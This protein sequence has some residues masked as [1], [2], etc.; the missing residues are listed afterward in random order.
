MEMSLGR[1]LRKAGQ[2]QRIREQGLHAVQTSQQEQL[3]RLV[4]HARQNSSFYEKLYHG[5]PSDGFLLADLPVTTKAVIMEHYDGVVT[6]ARLK[7]D[8]VQQFTQDPL[9][10][11]KAY[12]GEFVI[13]HTSGTT[14]LRGFVAQHITE[15]E[16]FFALNSLRPSKIPSTPGAWPRL[17]KSIFSGFRVAVI[18]GTGV[19]FITPQAFLIMP[20]ILKR[21][22]R[23]D[24]LSTLLPVNEMVDRLNQFQPDRIHGYPTMLEALAHKQ[25]EGTLAIRPLDISTSSEPLTPR[26]RSALKA[27][28]GV[29]VENTYGATETWVMAKECPYGQ[30]H[31]FIDGCIVEPVDRK[32]QPTPAGKQSA[33][34]LVT[35]LHNFSQP[36]LRYEMSDS[37]IQ[38]DGPCPCGSPL[39]RITVIGREDDTLYCQAPDG[40]YV[41]FPPMPLETLMLEVK[42]YSMFQIEQVERNRIRVCFVPNQGEDAVGIQRQ[43]LHQFTTHFQRHGLGNSV[44]VEVEA[45]REVSRSTVSGKGKQIA[46]LVGPPAEFR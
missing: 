16:T 12:Q 40:S 20:P 45:V 21:L 44:T 27:A 7:K 37:V 26:A 33:R 28:F 38:Q 14:G 15:W 3:K 18:A 42:G 19:Y 9:N 2:F 46:S 30:M 8:E 34:I 36:I 39:P 1:I 4:G 10:E 17:L 24:I 25:M 35:N 29:F 43:I 41:A 11:G 22:S 6:D 5:F 31:L 23:V 13:T 32:N